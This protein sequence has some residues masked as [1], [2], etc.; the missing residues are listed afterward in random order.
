[1]DRTLAMMQD[2]INHVPLNPN[3]DFV[4]AGR[5]DFELRKGQARPPKTHREIFS[6]QITHKWE[7]IFSFVLTIVVKLA[8]HEREPLLN[9]NIPASRRKEFDDLKKEL[10]QALLPDPANN[11]PGVAWDIPDPKVNKISIRTKVLFQMTFL[12]FEHS[13]QV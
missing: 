1:M 9:N 13:V 4:R 10:Q 7:K 6:F 3:G 11:R 5:N 8:M 2:T 12:Y